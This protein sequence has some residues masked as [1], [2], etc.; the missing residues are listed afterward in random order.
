M[1]ELHPSK[2]TTAGIL[3]ALAA[4][5][6]NMIAALIHNTWSPKAWDE[7]R[8][9][10]EFLPDLKTKLYKHDILRFEDVITEASKA[11]V[12]ILCGGTLAALSAAAQILANVMA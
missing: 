2:C 11:R 12:W 3:F 10:H 4:A 9:R 5:F 1:V 7:L 6:V 8:M